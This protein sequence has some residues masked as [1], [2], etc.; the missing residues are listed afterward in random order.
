MRRRILTAVLLL[1]GTVLPGC[2]LVHLPAIH[3]GIEAGYEQC[4]ANNTPGSC[5]KTRD[6]GYEN[7]H[8]LSFLMSWCD[9]DNMYSG[10]HGSSGYRSSPARGAEGTYYELIP[11]G[12]EAYQPAIIQAPNGQV[13]TCSQGFAGSSSCQ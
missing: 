1:A 10:C 2:A 9:A 4:V 12:K 5:E 13:L 3:R 7:V 11:S 8:S 6:Q